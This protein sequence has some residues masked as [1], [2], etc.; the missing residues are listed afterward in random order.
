MK[1]PV[2]VIV[3][4]YRPGA[5][6]DACLASVERELESVP[7]ELWVVDNASGDGS[8]ERVRK[9]FPSARVEVMA[10]NAGFAAANNMALERSEA[11]AF[12][13]LNPDAE[14]LPGS[15]AALC[16]AA[17]EHPEAGAVAPQIVEEDGRIAR[18]CRTA[19]SAMSLLWENTLLDLANPG[20]A[21]FDAHRLGAFDYTTARAVDAA[22][23]AC[24]FVTR[25]CV[26][27]I[28]PMDPGFFMYSEEMDW[29][30]RMRKGGLIVWF[31]PRARV[32]HLGQRSSGNY[33][34]IL[35]PA[36]YRSQRRYFS[37]HGSWIARALFGP[38]T[39]LGVALRLLGFSVRRVLGRLDGP[40]Y[41]TRVRAY[42]RAGME[43]FRAG[44]IR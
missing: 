44:G 38:L 26:D 19:P 16:R 39:L 13:L 18:S 36:Y 24:L 34:D 2:A 25:A 7:H 33:Q 43:A 15:Y 6:L 10:T 3:V 11:G 12:L 35:I 23:G 29:C 21:V 42:S 14:L 17:A 32:R 5:E 30:R 20:S 27:R 37:R 31:D 4:T 22:S 8:P 28:G 9:A 41:W 40:A 1:S